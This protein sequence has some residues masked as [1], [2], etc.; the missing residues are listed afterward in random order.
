[1]PKITPDRNVGA[2]QWCR[3]RIKN[4]ITKQAKTEQ[5]PKFAFN[6]RVKISGHTHP[7]L[8]VYDIDTT[9]PQNI[10][11][12]LAI[13]NESGTRENAAPDLWNN[14]AKVHQDNLI[15]AETENSTANL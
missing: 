11:Y 14:G 4:L 8:R 1:M 2:L 7:P 6:K 10:T 5:A 9:D 3:W 15:D 12:V 13:V